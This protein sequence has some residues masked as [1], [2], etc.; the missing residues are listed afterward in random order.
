MPP[1]PLIISPSSRRA[2]HWGGSGL[3]L[4]GVAFVAF[5]LHSYW[6]RLDPSKLSPSAW[7]LIA[8]LAVGY[9]AANLLLALAWRHLLGHLGAQAT[10]MGS[11]RIHGISQLAKYVPGNIFHLAGRQALGM[12]SGLPGGALARSTVWE[13]GL[14]AVAGTLFVCLIFPLAL[15]GFPELASALLLVGA[16]ALVAGLLRKMAGSQPMRAFLWQTTFL[17]ISGA[18]FIALLVAVANGGGLPARRWPG[19]GGAYVVAWLVGLVTPGAPGGLGVREM[20]L[21]V[22]L[23]GLVAETDL[24]MAVLVGRLLTVTGDLLFFMAAF[25]IPIKL[26]AFGKN[27]V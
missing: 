4:A 18:V 1:A 26:C 6:G 10:L 11:V 22:L 15:P 3:A 19:I 12:A 27:H 5:R 25:L 8:A 14:L 20:A 9:G 16:V 24:L 23:D 2:L 21:L 13:L 7:L 17:L